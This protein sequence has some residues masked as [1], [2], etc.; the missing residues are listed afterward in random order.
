MEG[1]DE[2]KVIACK[3]SR[4]QGVPEGSSGRLLEKAAGT[5]FPTRVSGFGNTTNLNRNRR[6]RP[7]TSPVVGRRSRPNLEALET[8]QLLSTYAVTNTDNSGAGS[9]RQA[10]INA[11]KDTSPD[12]I[13]FNIPASTAL[14]LDVPVPGFDSGTQT[15]RIKLASP[16]PAITNTVSIDGYS[17]A[18]DAGVPYRYSSHTSAVQDIN[19]SG[20]PTGGS[21]TLTTASPLPANTTA[22]IPWNASALVVQAALGAIV[23]P[24]NV[25]VTGGPAPNTDL[26]ITFQNKYAQQTIQPLV[27]TNNLTGGTNPGISVYT[28]DPGGT[29]LPNPNLTYIQSVP[30]TNDAKQ[31]N[32]AEER[33]I[34]DGSQTTG[35]T[36]FVLDASHSLLR[37]LIISG[38][39]VGVSVPAL[40]SS[41]NPV[42]GDLI[43][44]NSI[45]DYF[46][47]PVDP[48]TGSPLPTPNTVGFVQGQGNTQQGVV[49]YSS[50]TTVGGSNPQENN[51]ICGNGAQG[52]LV[53]P[54]AS[55]NQI[56]G[57]QIG[58]A[59]PSVNG[60]YVQ[61]GNGAEGVLIDSSGSLANPLS[62]VYASSNFVGSATGG[63]VISGNAGAG[64]RLAGVG[65]IRNLIRG[66]YI[67][68]APGGGYKFGTGN[69]GNAGDGVRIEDGSQNQVGGTSA[70]LGNTIASNHGA[71]IYITGLAT[72]NVAANNMIGVTAAGSQVLG[73]WSDGVA[74]YSPSNTIGPGNVISQNLRG[75]G[76]YGPSAST[77][78]TAGQILVVDN[79]IGTDSTGQQGFGNAYE[80]VRI[81]N[82]SDNTIQGN[83]SGSQVISGNQVGVALIGAQATGNLLEGNFIGSD[84]TGFKDLGNKNEGV[85]IE[86]AASNTIGGNMARS[87][88]LIS[89]NH[90]GIRLDGAGATGNA[91]EGNYIGTDISGSTRLGN[92]VDGVILSN[93]ASLNTIGGAVA[94]LGNII[95]F[96]VMTGVLVESGT[97]D[98]IRSNSIFSNGLLGIDLVAPGDPPSGVTP[99]APGVR[100]GPNNL[101][102]YPVLTTVTS[103]GSVTHIQGTLN[104][105]PN[106][107]FL[108][109]FFT[110]LEADAS[111][112][113]Q[114][115]TAFGSTQVTTDGNGDATINLLLASAFPQGSVLS[116][117]ATNLTTGDTSEFAQDSTESA[118]FQFTQATYVTSES[119]GTALI[120][121]S[122][123]LTSASASIT[124]AT[125]SGGAATPGT[126]YIPVTTI[127]TFGVGVSTQTFAVPILDPH[128][129]GGSRTVNLAL[130]NPN[131]A[132]TNAID[133]QPTAVLQI[134]D[135]DSGA[136]GS[137]IVT[138]TSDSGAGSLRQAIINADAA[139]SPSDILFDIPAATDPLLSIPVPGFD[140]STQTWT[141]TLKSP[142]PAITQ[143]VSIDGYSEAITGVPFRYPSQ[144][145]S[146]VQVVT[147]TGILTGG[148]FTLSTVAPLP[149]GTT[150]PIAY[151]ATP[152]QLQAALSAIQGMAG[153]I[154]VSGSPGFYSVTFQAAFAGQALSNLIGNSSGLAGTYPG[155]QVGTLVQGGTALSNPTMITSIPNTQAAVDANN[156]HARVIIN[157][158]QTGGGT[159]FVIEAS[160]CR[161]DGLIIDGFGVGVS[162]PIP[163]DVGNLIQG[164]F[165]GNYL[166]YPVDPS[167]GASLSGL[168]SIE[169]AGLGNLKQGVY[170]GA[171]NTTIG[172]TNPQE[173]NVIAGNLEQGIWIDTAATGNVIEGN[174]IG[175][176]GP[177]SNGLYFQVGNGAEGVLVDGSSNAIGGSGDAAANVISGNGGSGIH[178][179]GP[180]ATRTIVGA[181]L[182]GLAPGGGYLMGT[183]SPGNGGS[184]VL[185][186]NSASN[187][188]GGPDSTWGN[189][190]S[191]NSGAGVLIK[192]AASTG[193][194]VLNNMIGLTADGKGVKGNLDDGVAVDSPQNTIG[195]GNVISGNLRGVNISGPEASEVVV[196]GNLIGTDSTG[197]IDL[198]NATEGILI[199]NATDALIEGDAEGSQ[200][201]SGNLQGVVIS[202]ATSTRNLVEGNLIGT[203]KTGLYAIPNAQEGVAIL[204]ATG[205]TIG[206]T[207]AAALNLISANNWGVR[208]DG[209]SALANLVEGNLIGTDITGK[210]PLGNEVNGVIVSNNAAGNT[211]GGTV[212]GAGNTIAFNVLT[213]VR[214]E[215]G[216]GDSI[217]SNS[218]YSNGKLG[219]DLVAPGDPP[220]GVTPNAPGVRSGP[221]NLQNYPVLTTAI[222]GGTSSSIQGTLNSLP[223]TSFL[224]QFFTNQIP[225]PSGFGQ[226]QTSIGSTR[227]TTDASGNTPITFAPLNSLPANIW[228]T[229]TATNTSTGDTSEFSN[230]VSAQ[231]IT[232]QF[233]TA[234]VSVDVSAGSALVHVER[235][236]NLNAIVA[237]N[238]A[239]SNGTAVAGQDYSAASGTLT[240]QGGETDKT[241]SITI[242][243]NPSQAASSVTVNLALSQPTGGSTLGSPSTATLTINNNLPP[244]LQFLSSSYTTYTGSNSSI[245]TVTRGGGSRSTT[246]QVHYATAGGFAVAGVDYT[247]VSG[248]LTFL[249][250]QT[251]ATFTVPILHGGVATVTKTVGLVLAGPTAAAQLG[252][253]STA[254]LTIMAGSPYNPGGPTDT[255][256][257][258]ITGEQLVLGPAGITAVLFSFS[259]PLNPSRV[260][261]LGNYGYYV[262]VAGANGAFGTPNDSYIPL[263]AAQYN[264]ATS[265]VTVIPSTPL[266]LNRFER[267]TIDGLANPLLGRGLIDT[268]GNLLSGQSNGVPGSPFIVTFGVG[269]SLAYTDS[270]GKTVQLSLTGGGLIEMFRTPVG[271]VQTVSLLGAVPRK[272][273]LTLQANNAGGRTTYLPPVQGAAG[274]RFRYRTPASVFRST[275]LPLI[276]QTP[277]VKAA[278]I[279]RRK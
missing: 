218:I 227:V 245:V 265:T 231:P 193:N 164:N 202:G 46:V 139:S 99:N 6:R 195:P 93:S 191:S 49:L 59:G 180:V 155:I 223:S 29:V 236:G 82:S 205:N 131:P 45:G 183:G 108:I 147:L 126:D 18:H 3:S 39:S 252:P 158:S 114:G 94:G 17:Q 171:N 9:L 71:G 25:T 66:N 122:R 79:L 163:G 272:S 109:Q 36:G 31:G 113:G 68:V 248:T 176:I 117:T 110:N 160:H 123:S 151:N 235:A 112:Y 203:D 145:T 121:V 246:V 86:G 224:I 260:P 81:D 200:V 199:Q 140:P 137:F 190:I 174:Q 11:N 206:G 184:G 43:Q 259:K 197:A 105:L 201:I 58:M 52:I 186:E 8:R 107:S 230:A 153:N 216:T 234:S 263:S 120:T 124:C 167:T 251:T 67:G 41:G 48:N 135:N 12:D 162:V 40:D 61:D 78:G 22:P 50:N 128:L 253:I 53:Q 241:F 249:A 228:V 149:Q 268:S 278:A 141:I 156:A 264:P 35:A 275:P 226:G 32:N 210:A 257:P 77:L 144:I 56:L 271:D 250:N 57:N 4:N 76:I 38:F 143:T 83:S 214:V 28:F 209:P 119:S 247:P 274:V 256:P 14:L 127:L 7:S 102:N 242:L 196:Q 261:D 15:W 262:D 97:G 220:S 232:M 208:L 89:A 23:G 13:V 172:G 138:N 169:L 74:L 100:S 60:L 182:I 157:G 267:I 24:T 80:G 85:L 98:S 165:I 181:N 198:G 44:G 34:I 2:T 221:N 69:P 106:T 159:G 189:T 273:V 64:V 84:K 27:A 254:T 95:A 65:A 233:L 238:Y 92:E 103:N 161:L 73:N 192:G 175:M 229:A 211:I 177:S 51:I 47:Y 33:V 19:I 118:V 75:I 219:I 255:I 148:T 179:V 225:D 125:V 63:N 30:N 170:V 10:I 104:S 276:V 142:L 55:G 187:V 54:G 213:G 111:G 20:S 152:A 222:G 42:V 5:M 37:G 270:L 96:Q 194:T 207:T 279:K 185:I 150:G 240:F 154:A 115:Q 239:I 204:G 130:S 217:L 243:P 269:S 168:N 173:N 26:I 237:V 188:I 72:G 129:V 70:V 132:T 277:R 101:Q 133:F 244:I 266:P 166:L 258:R 16:L 146:A 136:S 134:K 90:W 116:A 1:L 215:S 178:I 91:I 87:R 88:N 212:S 62:I 21:F